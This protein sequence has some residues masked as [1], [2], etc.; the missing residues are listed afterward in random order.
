MLKIDTGF[1]P[2]PKP[3]AGEKPPDRFAAL[4]TAQAADLVV[5]LASACGAELV[6]VERG[7]RL[8]LKLVESSGRLP[9]EGWELLRR[10]GVSA[11]LARRFHDLPNQARLN[12]LTEDEVRRFEQCP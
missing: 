10:H 6:S 9:P 3:P 4:G 12:P 1:G 2:A 8:E 7:H 5:A 11:E